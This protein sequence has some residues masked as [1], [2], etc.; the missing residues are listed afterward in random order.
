MRKAFWANYG[1]TLEM[2][3]ELPWQEMDDLARIVRLETEEA[4]LELKANQ[5]R[6]KAG[7]P[8]TMG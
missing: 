7:R 3:Q 1:L 8:R 5:N 2:A 6:S 4:N